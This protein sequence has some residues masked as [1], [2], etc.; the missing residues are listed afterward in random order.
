MVAVAQKL[1]I[2]LAANLILAIF[3]AMLTKAGQDDY[4]ETSQSVFVPIIAAVCSFV[5]VSVLIKFVRD[6][7]VSVMTGLLLAALG[8]SISIA[9]TSPVWTLESFPAEAPWGL[10]VAALLYVFGHELARR[11][12]E[13]PLFYKILSAFIGGFLCAHGSL[14]FFDERE[15]AQDLADAIVRAAKHSEEDRSKIENELRFQL[16]IYLGISFG[17]LMLRF[18][19]KG[20]WH[21]Y[22]PQRFR[23]NGTETQSS[24]SQMS[25]DDCSE[26][27]PEI[28]QAK[29]QCSRAKSLQDDEKDI[30]VPHIAVAPLDLHKED[31]MSDDGLDRLCAV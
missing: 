6:I 3:V 9:A 10:G 24:I 5:C 16:A 11:N 12:I 20:I 23:S 18:A 27:D 15:F 2:L 7:M 29:K 19:V 21:K 17:M 31:E 8:L 28:G 14:F 1:T 22:K 30:S 25:F 4:S 26:A 13:R